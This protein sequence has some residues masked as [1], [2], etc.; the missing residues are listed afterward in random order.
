M[1]ESTQRDEE[2]E[3]PHWNRVYV[4]LPAISRTPRQSQPTALTLRTYQLRK[5]ECLDCP[6]HIEKERGIYCLACRCPQWP[7]SDLRTK[8]R[9]LDIKCPLNKW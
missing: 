5:A 6:E 3:Y 1:N 7:M 4:Q 2:R 8:W 9:M